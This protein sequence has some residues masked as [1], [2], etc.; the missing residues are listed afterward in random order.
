MFDWFWE[1]LYSISE[2]L[3]EIIDGLMSIANMLCGIE[4]ITVES[5]KTDF[6]SYLLNNDKVMYGFIGAGLV[7]IFLVMVFSIFAMIKAIKGKSE[8]TPFRVVA[9]VFKTLG[10]FLFVPFVMIAFSAI[11]NELMIVLYKATSMGAESMG[12]FLFKAFLPDGMDPSG[13]VNFRDVDS[14]DAFMEL[15][16]YDLDDYKFFFSWICCIPL[17]FALAK[18]LLNFVDRTISIVLL[19]ITS[20]LS[21]STSIIDDGAHFKLWRDQVLIKFLTG[22][23][24]IIGLNVYILVVSIIS[25]TSV[26]FFENSFLNFLFKIA[27]MLGGAL[28]LERVMALVGNLVSSGAGSNELRD[29][30]IAY[31]GMKGF[32]GGLGR[33]AKGIAKAPVNM[34]NGVNDVKN[35]GLGQTVAESIGLKTER[36]YKN[37]GYVNGKEKP[38][39]EQ[40]LDAIIGLKEDKDKPKGNKDSSQ[41]TESGSAFGS[42]EHNSKKSEDKDAKNKNLLAMIG[43]GDSKSNIK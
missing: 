25:N 23:G 26:V 36:D 35:K 38:V 18:G 28:S 11:V 10:V 31:N 2:I 20:P 43:D 9:K 15:S 14:V 41:F 13:F 29:S 17:L 37:M 39:Q 3:F 12:D 6:L 1:F 33:L 32:A 22:Y 19:F 21:I 24:I 7:G 4:P 34:V 8:L 27:F 16:G 42:G 30:A 5:N 40:I